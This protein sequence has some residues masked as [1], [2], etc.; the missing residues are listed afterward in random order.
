MSRKKLEK[1]V[2]RNLYAES[3]GRCMNPNCRAVLFREN[4]DVI[5]KAHIDPYCKNADNTFENLVVLCPTCHTDFDKNNAFSPEEVLEWKKIRKKEL[6]SF[7]SK[8]MNTFEE[9]CEK[10]VPLLS[11][12]KSI[13]DEYY[14][15]NKKNLWDKFEPT[16]LVNNRKIKLLLENNLNL[17]QTR[18]DS[19]FETNLDYVKQLL[20]HIDEFE[21]TRVDEEKIRSATFPDKIYSIFG[22]EPLHCGIVPMTEALENL[23]LK[24]DCREVVLGV[25]NPYIVAIL[26]NQQERIFL[27]DRPRVMQ[28]FFNYN[29]FKKIGMRLESLNFA[30]KYLNDHGVRFSFCKK[31]NLREINCLGY[32]IIFV[33]EY[34]LSR[35]FF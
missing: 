6:E 12:N 1:D 25:T 16:I 27:D 32:H 10:I 22:I 17:I 18:R 4:G 24:I 34:C 8:K 33:Y 5:E 30:L 20:L 29:C 3:M 26:N 7:F 11:E 21:K 23:I 19:D 35:N 15:G 28:L 13:F 14:I 9:L 2:E 31:N